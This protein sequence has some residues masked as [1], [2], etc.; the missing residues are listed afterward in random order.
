N[1]MPSWNADGT[2]ILFSRCDRDTYQLRQIRAAYH[3]MRV[4]W[5]TPTHPVSTPHITTDQRDVF[6]FRPAPANL[7]RLTVKD[8]APKQI[9]FDREGANFPTPSWDGKWVAYELKRGETTQIAVID[10]DG[11]HQEVL[12]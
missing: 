11:G 10:R 1:G 8:G 3:A 12:T 7:W 6:F 9:T 5:E 4:L 2:A